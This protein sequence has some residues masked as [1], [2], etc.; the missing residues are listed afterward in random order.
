MFF[1][2]SRLPKRNKEPRLGSKVGDTGARNPKLLYAAEGDTPR[3][4]PL[5]RVDREKWTSHAK[6]EEDGGREGEGKPRGKGGARWDGGLW[7]GIR[8]ILW[9]D[10]ASLRRWSVMGD[11]AFFGRRGEGVEVKSSDGT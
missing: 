1:E 5:P 10:D 6:G 3:C 2:P 8:G 4:P 7:G 11:A 9:G